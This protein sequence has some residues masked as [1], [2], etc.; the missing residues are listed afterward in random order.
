MSIKSTIG[1]P[2]SVEHRKVKS[3]C[4]LEVVLP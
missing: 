4:S 3:P 2:S 1:N